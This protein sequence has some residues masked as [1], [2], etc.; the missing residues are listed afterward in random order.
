MQVRVGAVG[1]ENGEGGRRVELG[2]QPSSLWEEVYQDLHTWK[3]ILLEEKPKRDS[4]KQENSLS[5]SSGLVEIFCILFLDTFKVDI[6]V[7]LVAKN[8]IQLFG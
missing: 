6:R 8:S 1:I 4:K 2:V 7:S 3:G 5:C